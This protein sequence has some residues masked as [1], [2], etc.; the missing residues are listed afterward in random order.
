[1]PTSLAIGDFSGLTETAANTTGSNLDTGDLLRKFA[2]GNYFTELRVMQDPF[3]RAL[4]TLKGRKLP[5]NSSEFKYTEK[6]NSWMKRYAYVT[7]HGSS[8]AVSSTADAT[9]T[10][11]SI[12]AGDTYFF[13]MSTDYKYAG[14]K[15]N[16]YGQATGAFDV[17][18][19]GTAPQ[20]FLVGQVIKIPFGSAFNVCNDYI[21]AKITAIT[22]VATTHKVLTTEIVRTLNTSTNN[23]LQWASA[24][25]PI[26]TNYTTTI[27]TTVTSLESKRTYVHGFAAA[28]GSGVPNT[29]A[30]NPY[31]TAE[32]KC[33]IWKTSLAIDGSTASDEFKYE[34]NQRARL[35]RD[36]LIEHKWDIAG[37]LYYSSLRTDSDGALHTEGALDFGLKYGNIFSLDITS[38]GTTQDDFLDHLSQ[39][40]DPR[41]GNV[42]QMVFFA[43][44]PTYNWM[45]KLSGYFSN[46]VQVTPNY[47]AEFAFTGRNIPLANKTGVNANVIATPYGDMN[48]VHDVHLDGSGVKLQGIPLSNVK[49]RP[50]VGNG[51]NRDT[52]IYM[53]VQTLQSNG[54]DKIVDLI[55][56]EAA[57]EP[58][59]GETWATWT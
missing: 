20:F 12:E 27:A 42:G 34:P 33:E 2:A 5:V 1:M 53:G 45:N 57:L 47:T 4:S 3:L 40:N 11:T 54:V 30:D 19:A 18:A 17:G 39:I 37:S 15:S 36:K 28:P 38:S 16:I 51:M 32:G 7:A 52:T 13:K 24:T 9:V 41:I 59:M 35:W 22:D 25:A 58:S 44:K 14:N 48:V 10:A 8:S 49:Y 55:M 46:N 29:W 43:D 31:S 56:T 50:K 26:S 21:L 6:R 23:E